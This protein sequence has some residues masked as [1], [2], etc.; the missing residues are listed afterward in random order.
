MF[1]TNTVYKKIKDSDN[2]TFSL[3]E[4]NKNKDENCCLFKKRKKEKVIQSDK[5]TNENQKPKEKI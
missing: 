5:K 3:E 4:S 2:K 1:L